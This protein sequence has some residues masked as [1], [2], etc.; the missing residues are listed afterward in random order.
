[1]MFLCLAGKNGARLIRI[2]A[3][4]DDGVNFLLQKFIQMLGGAR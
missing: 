2:A 3:Y 1:M 4:G